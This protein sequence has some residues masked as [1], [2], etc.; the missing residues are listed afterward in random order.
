M[1]A[2]YRTDPE[3]YVPTPEPPLDPATDRALA[4]LGTGF[5]LLG[6]LALTVGTVLVAATGT[7]VWMWAFDE[8]P[9]SLVAPFVLF[10]VTA[11]VLVLASGARV[12]AIDVREGRHLRRCRL[13]GLLAILLGGPPGLVLG[14]A[15]LVA[16]A[17]PRLRKL[18]TS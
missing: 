5:H 4:L 15:V 7:S 11:L 12:V 16:L 14:V 9:P 13:A 6:A 2:P 1:L 3:A 17:R 8:P 18:F 10:P